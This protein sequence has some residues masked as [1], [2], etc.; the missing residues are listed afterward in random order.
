MNN[1]E[2]KTTLDVWRPS[3]RWTTLFDHRPFVAPLWTLL[4]DTDESVL[5]SEYYGDHWE[6]IAERQTIA[7]HIVAY[8]TVV[9]KARDRLVSRLGPLLRFGEA[10]RVFSLGRVMALTLAPI[11]SDWP[12]RLDASSAMRARG[13]RYAQFLGHAVATANR[14]PAQVLAQ[15]SDALALLMDILRGAVPQ[16]GLPVADRPLAS[17]APLGWPVAGNEMRDALLG[18]AVDC[19]TS[20]VEAMTRA[21]KQWEAS[22]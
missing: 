12:L 4:F 20:H 13:P 17:L 15:E 22:W 19:P 10:W 6:G 16:G 1:N 7:D 18:R 8:Q 3:E 5:A 9:G 21:R 2:P 14:L 11:P